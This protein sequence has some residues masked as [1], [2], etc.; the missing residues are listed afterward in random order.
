MSKT[1]AAATL[2]ACVILAAATL[3][4]LAFWAADPMLAYANNYDQIRALRTFGL[5]PR[6]AKQE[7]YAATPGQPWRYFVQA[8]K[9]HAP[10]YPS[11]D[12][13][14]KSIQYGTM[15][16]FAHGDGSMD[17]KVG[18][19]PQLIAWLLGVWLI[20]RRLTPRPMAALGYAGWMLLVADPINLLFLNTWYAE[21]STFAVATLFVGIAWL[22][23]FDRVSLRSA[24]IWGTTSLIFISLSRSQYMF[25]LPAVALLTGLAL[26][27]S[28]PHRGL[29][30]AAPGKL[31]LLALICLLPTLVYK[32]ASEQ[33]RTATSANRIDTVF[34]A[35]LPASKDQDKMLERLGLPSGCL[36]FSGRNWYDTPTEQYQTH[37][38]KVMT[39]SLGKIAKALVGD[40]TPL[41][42]IIG[43]IAS[44][45]RGFLQN[46]LGHIEGSVHARIDTSGK[47]HHQSLD[48]L[49]GY[50]SASA[51]HLL[52]WFSIL[53]PALAALAAWAL[54][55]RRWAFVFLL[56]GLLFNY[57]LF[58]SILGDGYFD[59]A[60]HAMLCFSFGALFFALLA[61]FI[62]SGARKTS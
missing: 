48:R 39:L 51:T 24:L 1:N 49:L 44:H 21:F 55:Q 26:A 11:S 61:T 34:G 9:R 56:N 8:D 31:A 3:R 45:H 28:R 6:D 43:N 33:V 47:M 52:L 12:L 59:L 54:R 15:A 36:Q 5:Q 50:L 16:A 53:S 2:L 17:I 20:F 41:V 19:A 25:L 32:T 62:A 23:L 58:S 10:T 42:T 38:P 57:A 60:R 27:L 7:L 46:Q 18:T 13:L 35:L 40:P 30:A 4:A 22:W 37:C 29:L 14:F